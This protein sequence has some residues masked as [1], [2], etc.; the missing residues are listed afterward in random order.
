MIAVI[1]GKPL[2]VGGASGDPEARCGR[3]AGLFAKGYKLFAV[4]G[5]RPAPEAYRVYPMNK[6]EDKV[7]EEMMPELTG[8]GYLLGDG[9]YDASAVYDAAGAAGYQ[10][11][12]PREDPEAGLGHHY[13]SPY[14]LR[15]IELLR[16]SFGQEVY[17]CGGHRARVRRA[18]LVRRRAVAAAGLGPARGPGVDVDRRQAGDQRR[19]DHEK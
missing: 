18:D 8:G 3:G 7:A 2:P 12:A 15:C 13:Q 17:H 10:L 1:D 6:S 11:L 4:W 9:E 16:T 19:A 5:G 14:R